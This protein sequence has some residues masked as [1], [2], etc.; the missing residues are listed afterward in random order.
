VGAFVPALRALPPLAQSLLLAGATIVLG[1]GGAETSCR[2]VE[3]HNP[4]AEEE[5]AADWTNW[6]G[7]FF[8]A[9]GWSPARD[10]NS[11]GLRDRQ[12][13]IAKLPGTRRWMCLGDST[14]Y[15][16]HLRPEQAYPQIL[17]TLLEARGSAVEVFNVALPGWAARQEL[18]AYR[19]ICRKYDPDLLLVGICL[20]DIPD[21]QNNLSQPP[22]ALTW[23]HRHSALVRW[24]VDAE[25]RQI[26]SVEELFAPQ[27][28]GQ[29]R[30][31]YE[32][33]MADLRRLRREASADGVELA[34]V[35]LPLR[36]QVVAGAPPPRPQTTLAEFGRAE[37]IPM[38][39]LLPA[40]R[41]AGPAAFIDADHL[42]ALGTR[43]VAEQLLASRLLNSEA[44]SRSPAFELSSLAELLRALDDPASGVRAAAA[45][46]LARAGE[47]ARPAGPALVAR[48]D[49]PDE[50]VRLRAADALVAIGPSPTWLPRLIELLEQEASPAQAVAARVVAAMGP[51]A[52]EAVPSLVAAIGESDDVTRSAIA[53]ALAQ[54]GPDARAAVPALLAVMAGQGEARFRAV[55]AVGLIRDP[56]AVTALCDAL[57]DPAGDMR[58]QAARALG[59]IGPAAHPC[60]PSL[61]KAL[62]DASSDVRMAALRALPRLG[63]P[64]D[65]LRPAVEELRSDPNAE[66][67]SEAGQ[68]LRKLA[69]RK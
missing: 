29:I 25:G 58:W 48:L 8:T 59:R 11:D 16:F 3:R 26:R 22:R 31:G 68:V 60:A 9:R 42:S 43:I 65:Q 56:S 45:T 4:P 38:L 15:G 52:R 37:G 39:D 5:S 54:I 6:E 41:P 27:P 34:L 28:S 10:Y 24:A 14:T 7:E 55:E 19:R 20:N 47:D 21:M 44:D 36:A 62:K 50:N 61:L 63:V 32:R 53:L 57:R 49:D 64:P 40:L 67:R 35:V 69:V 30:A 51:A 17:Q 66:V 46:A 1:V 12:H 18:I 2:M 23:L 33:L 13:A